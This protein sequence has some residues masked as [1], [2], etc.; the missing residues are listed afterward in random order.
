[1]GWLDLP[2][3]PEPEVMDDSAE[4]EAYASAAAQAYLDRIDDTFVGHALRLVQRRASGRALDLGTGP[5]QIVLKL[6]ARLPGWRFVGIDRSPNM[7][8]QA[9]VNLATWSGHR[10][11]GVPGVHY[12]M[13]EANELPIHERVEFF[14]ADGNKLALP[15]ASFDLVMSNSV[16]H[17]LAHPEE[18]LAEIARLARPGAA[19]L[20]RDLRRPSRLAYPLHVRWFGRHYSGLMYRLY[21]ASVRSAYTEHELEDL[22]RF[23]P[24]WMANANSAGARI[25]R[26]GRT[27]LGIERPL[28]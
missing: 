24:L 25:F 22:L 18:V 26:F 3:V 10:P 14:V 17:H 1:M 2:R 15:D 19:I 5:G 28:P 16:L 7:I 12:Q 13:A 20:I 23:S 11:S 8:A 21:A 4:V 27:H 6:A 9:R